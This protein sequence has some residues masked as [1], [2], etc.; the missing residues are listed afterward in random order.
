MNPQRLETARLFHRFGFGPRPGEF[1]SALKNGVGQTR[2][3]VLAGSKNVIAVTPP[4]L[5]DLGP[6]PTPN[7]PEITEFSKNLRA[8]STSLSKWW[9]DQMVLSE[10]QLHEKMVW[11]WHGHWATSIGKVNYALPMYNQN[12]TF[13]N[14]ALGNFSDFAVAMFFDGALQIWLDGGENTLKAPN[15]NLSR[16]MMELF[17]LGVNRYTESD[18]KELARAFTGYQ[19]PRSSGKV[20]F[21]PKRRD[22]GAVTVLG[23]TGVMSPEEVI[24]HLVAQQDCAKFINERIWYRFISSSAPLPNNL[25]AIDAFAGRD[26]SALIKSLLEDKALSSPDYSLVK[27]PVEWFVSVCRAFNLVPSQMNSQNKINNYLDKLSQIPFSPPNV[28][29]WPTD[30]AWLSSASAQFRLA[31]AAWISSQID[32]S[33]LTLVAP[34]RRVAY[35]E[36]LLGVVEWS[37]RTAFALREVRNNPERLVTLA[38]CSPEYV[39]SA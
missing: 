28:G 14:Y 1:E 12:L 6:R 29:G 5:T 3:S 31:F 13:R 24:K 38:I 36:N 23:K 35:L 34:E 9:L 2:Q 33:Q 8:Q 21:N 4:E 32:L 18:V 19:I 17:V 25:A 27:S 15:E 11:F 22:N 39:V 10:N 37:P 16:E 20:N 30:E 7:S 26:I